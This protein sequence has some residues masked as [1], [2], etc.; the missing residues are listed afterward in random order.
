[1]AGHARA[2]SDVEYAGRCA[3]ARDV[4]GDY[5]DFLDL[6]DGRL[7]IVL[8]DVSGKGVPAA[9]LMANLQARMVE[10]SKMDATVMQSIAGV[11]ARGNNLAVPILAISHGL[12]ATAPGTELI[13]RPPFA[14]QRFRDDWQLSFSSCWKI[15]NSSPA[16]P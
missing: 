2:F 4:S 11:V 14:W 13:L 7:G 6:G 15:S 5:Y 3:P 9:L 10:Y 16:A 12:V 1:M 8:A